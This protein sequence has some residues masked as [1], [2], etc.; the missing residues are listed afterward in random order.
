MA[1]GEAKFYNRINTRLVV[2]GDG[3]TFMVVSLS[4]S[5]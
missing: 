4:A 1:R 5:V 2:H 3:V